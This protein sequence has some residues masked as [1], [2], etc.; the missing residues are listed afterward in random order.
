MAV[1]PDDDEELCFR[2]RSSLIFSIIESS[3]VVVGVVVMIVVEGSDFSEALIFSAEAALT[4][5]WNT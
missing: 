5:S 1:P 4:A 2:F 3:D